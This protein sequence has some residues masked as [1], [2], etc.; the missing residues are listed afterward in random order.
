MQ[1]RQ[2]NAIQDT[3][4]ANRIQVHSERNRAT[5]GGV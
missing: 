1:K 3:D 4:R 2:D 5:G